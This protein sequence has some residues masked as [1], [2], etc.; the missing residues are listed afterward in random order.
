ME[1]QNKKFFI[2]GSSRMGGVKVVTSSLRDS[3]I[4]LGYSVEYIYGLKAIKLILLR[5]FILIF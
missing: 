2:F 5:R 1:S 4:S 3:L